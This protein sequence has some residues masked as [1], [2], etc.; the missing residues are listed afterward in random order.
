MTFFFKIF[1]F[2]SFDIR[3]D[4]KGDENMREKKYQW[5]YDRLAALSVGLVSVI[6][7]IY[8]GMSI[9]MENYFLKQQLG[10]S[11]NTHV[12]IRCFIALVIIST[13]L[14]SVWGFIKK[15][16]HRRLILCLLQT[17]ILAFVLR[18]IFIVFLY[19]GISFGIMS[20]NIVLLLIQST[21]IYHTLFSKQ[22]MTYYQ[23]IKK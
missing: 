14:W 21:L 17:V 10:L 7:S 13:T 18:N 5:Q 19:D 22:I 8:I 23:L 1:T 6:V 16:H 9:I 12:L 20:V 4:E 15:V 11:V 3:I 2:V